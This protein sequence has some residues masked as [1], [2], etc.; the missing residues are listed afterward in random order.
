MFQGFTPPVFV[1]HLGDAVEDTIG[2]GL[3]GE[4]VV[5]GPGP[6]AHLPE[7]P[8]QD[9][10]GA[11]GFPPLRRKVIEMQAV[12]EV[13]FHALH[14][15]FLFHPP[16]GLPA[17]EAFDGLFAVLGGEDELGFLETMSLVNLSDLYRHV[18]P[19][20]SDTA[21][22]FDKRVDGFQGLDQ[23]GVAIGNDELQVLA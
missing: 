5:H 6:S 15:P 16:S 20:M 10:G 8:F 9:I 1:E 13:L 3:I 23:A 11:D 12:K 18:A 4:A 7:S 14:G 19:F 21:L 17:L 2:T 22:H